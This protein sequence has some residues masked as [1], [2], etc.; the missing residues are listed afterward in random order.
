MC[1]AGKVQLAPLGWLRGHSQTILQGVGWERAETH[2]KY[3]YPFLVF[4][5]FPDFLILMDANCLLSVPLNK[6]LKSSRRGSHHSSTP[7]AISK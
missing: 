2:Y 5:G 7:S 6:I 4:F 3:L 1:V